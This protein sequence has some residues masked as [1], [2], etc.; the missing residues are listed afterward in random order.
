METHRSPLRVSLMHH[1]SL[2]GLLDAARGDQAPCW[3]VLQAGLRRGS[4][5]VQA[6][7]PPGS[8]DSV[9]AP[10]LILDLARP[11]VMWMFPLGWF[12][13]NRP[14]PAE[15]L[16]LL[17]CC[18]SPLL[19]IKF[20]ERSPRTLPDFLLHLGI[21]AVAMGTTAHLVTDS[22]KLRLVQAGYSLHLSV[23][24]N[25]LMKNLTVTQ[26]VD[27]LELLGYY[28]DTVGHVMW[29]V[30]FFLVLFLF[31]GGCF[32]HKKQQ[33]KMPVSAWILLLPNALYFW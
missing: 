16:H 6:S 2:T 5:S 11:V 25:Q 33:H 29:Y 3:R 14:G 17:Y 21:T 31:F 26:L 23:R 22:V 15:C 9:S 19:L 32:C 4:G 28:D 27:V 20:L 12:P 30:P 8:V 24:E 7:L 13:V 1:I 10:V 18:S